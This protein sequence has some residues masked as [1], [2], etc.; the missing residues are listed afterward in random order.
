MKHIILTL[1]LMITIQSISQNVIYDKQDNII[2]IDNINYVSWNYS[3]NIPANDIIGVKT[4]DV[5]IIIKSNN[6]SI[7]DVVFINPISDYDI[8]FISNNHIVIEYDDISNHIA[9]DRLFKFNIKFSV[10]GNCNTT[11]Y[12]LEFNQYTNNYIT[13]N[14]VYV[15]YRNNNNQLIDLG[16]IS[17]PFTINDSVTIVRASVTEDNFIRGVSLTQCDKKRQRILMIHTE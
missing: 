8:E 17:N 9:L 13:H 12:A 2:T 1:I 14:N 11:F 7:Y 4:S 5:G 3:D 16:Y 10:S 15:K 6:V